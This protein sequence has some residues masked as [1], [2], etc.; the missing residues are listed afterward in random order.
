MTS[1]IYFFRLGAEIVACRIWVAVCWQAVVGYWL[2]GEAAVGKV[3][4]SK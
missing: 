3:F 2:A 4:E 1:Q